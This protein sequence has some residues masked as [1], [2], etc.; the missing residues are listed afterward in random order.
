MCY[1]TGYAPGA[2]FTVKFSVS[3]KVTNNKE[4]RTASFYYDNTAPTAPTLISPVNTTVTTGNVALVRS[5][6]VDT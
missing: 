3:D 6:A 4:S 1:I 5:A 2:D